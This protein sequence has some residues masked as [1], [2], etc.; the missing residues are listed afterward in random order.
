[1]CADAFCSCVCIRPGRIF[2]SLERFMASVEGSRKVFAPIEESCAWLLV[3]STGDLASTESED[4]DFC[5][6]IPVICCYNMSKV[7]G[8]VLYRKGHGMFLATWH[9]A[10]ARNMHNFPAMQKPH[11]L[12]CLCTS[13]G[14]RC[15]C[16]SPSFQA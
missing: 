2:M 3:P 9:T 1:V 14:L 11:S 7:C 15:G 12:W 13:A 16:L 4:N 5:C 6:S 8:C 10:L